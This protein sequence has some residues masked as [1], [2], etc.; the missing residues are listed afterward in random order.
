MLGAAITN[1]HL[2]RD[3]RVHPL[4]TYTFQ[5]RIAAYDLT[6]RLLCSSPYRH[7]S[8]RPPKSAHPPAAESLHRPPPL[9]AG[10]VMPV[11]AFMTPPAAPATLHQPAAAPGSCCNASGRCDAGGC[12][13]HDAELGSEGVWP[14]SGPGNC[15]SRAPAARGLMVYVEWAHN[16]N[17]LWH[18]AA[19]TD[20]N[21]TMKTALAS[22]WVWQA[23]R[24]DCR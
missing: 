22:C 10:A 18:G 3:S 23:G 1:G 20:R 8:S 6:T 21:M 13:N 4:T 19:P 7:T 17:C 2:T 16:E 5:R 12:F 14:G 11:P 9:A 15:G 24:W